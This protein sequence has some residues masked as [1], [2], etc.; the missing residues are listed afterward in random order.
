MSWRKEQ[1]PSPGARLNHQ[2]APNLKEALACKRHSGL[3]AEK[4]AARYSP[5]SDARAAMAGVSPAEPYGIFLRDPA[6]ELLSS[7]L[8]Q[9]GL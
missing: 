2:R 9:R 5:F 8:A 7:H 3:I 4:G 6:N 1:P